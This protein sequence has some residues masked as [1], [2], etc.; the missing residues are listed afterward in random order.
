M[1]RDI[2]KYGLQDVYF[3]KS[4]FPITVFVIISVIFWLK[5]KKVMQKNL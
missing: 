3:F 5:K 1:S 4:K 2:A